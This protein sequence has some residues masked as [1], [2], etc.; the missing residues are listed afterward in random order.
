MIIEFSNSFDND[1]ESYAKI[2]DEKILGEGAT[3]YFKIY[4]KDGKKQVIE[5][6]FLKER[7]GWKIAISK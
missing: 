5:E 3:V 7:D 4:F 6:K 2:L 1:S